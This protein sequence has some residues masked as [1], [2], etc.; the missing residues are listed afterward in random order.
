MEKTYCVYMHKNKINGKIYIGQTCQKPEKRW[1]YGCGYKRHNLH[2]YNAIKKYG[3]NN[4]EHIILQQGLNLQ[5]ANEKEKYWIHYYESNNPD[6]GYNLTSGGDGSLGLVMSEEAKLKIGRE[7]GKLVQ[8]LETG[9]VYYSAQEAARQLNIS[10]SH[11]GDACNN[12]RGIAGGYHWE[13]IEFPID[14]IDRKKLIDK[15]DQ[16]KRER[17]SKSIICIETNE[18]FSGGKEAEEKTGISRGNICSCCK[19]N[20]K[21]AG[22]YHWK[23]YEG[24]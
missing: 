13:Y 11:I 16:L 6:K 8:C 19:G 14:E 17:Q 9:D 21:T 15:K 1:D 2:F 22:G 5:E 7:N 20:R 18:V 23:Y 3:W 4:F 24:E 10:A 12:K